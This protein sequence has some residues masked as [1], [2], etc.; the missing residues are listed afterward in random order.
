MR[1]A[2]IAFEKEMKALLLHVITNTD[3]PGKEQLNMA[4]LKECCD[5]GYLEGVITDTMLNGR[6]VAEVSGI[7]KVTKL[8]LD[9]LYPK[10]DVKFI[11]STTVAVCS[12]ILN[13][14]LA[15]C[16]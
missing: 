12:I 3:L 9:F 13:I 7:V 2:R 10:T 14:V 15:V 5:S 11:V 8:G 1:N 16:S 4:A 6:V